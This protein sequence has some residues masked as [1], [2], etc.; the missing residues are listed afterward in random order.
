MFVESVTR[1]CWILDYLQKHL[2]SLKSYLHDFFLQVIVLGTLCI[3]I[4]IT[5]II[6]ISK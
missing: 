4:T 5:I 1:S 6:I 2:I 3:A